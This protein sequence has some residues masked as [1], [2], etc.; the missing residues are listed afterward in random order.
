MREENMLETIV[1]RESARE[2]EEKKGTYD[3]GM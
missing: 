3:M 2:G 1:E